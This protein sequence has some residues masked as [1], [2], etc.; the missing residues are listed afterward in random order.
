MR[1]HDWTGF[2]A[3]AAFIVSVIALACGSLGWAF[4]WFV[5][6]AGAALLTR[7][8]SVKYP[9]PMPHLLRWTLLV[10][11]GTHSPDH[12]KQIL[13]PHGG[14][15]ILEIGPGVGIHS[16][17]VASAVAPDGQLDVLDVQQAM[18]DDVLRKA[19]QAGIANITAKQAD[20]QKLP[21]GDQVF[22]AAYLIGVLGEIP[23]GRATLRELRR[24]LKP[25][26]RLVV[27]EVFFDPDFIALGSLT[28]RTREAG[29]AYERKVGGAL[30]YLARFRPA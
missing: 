30:T 5:M 29:F 11:R 19:S 2:G 17:P 13:E 14:E 27:G 24:V 22:D 12:L 1:R 21:Y 9:A 16:L 20:A 18:L 25:N 7:Y 23:D 4:V 28:D 8:W 10:P 26:G 3:L 15:R 6:S